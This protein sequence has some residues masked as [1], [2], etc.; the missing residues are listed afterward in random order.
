ME[1]SCAA[2][3]LPPLK[4]HRATDVRA[5]DDGVAGLTILSGAPGRVKSQEQVL[6]KTLP[7]ERK[8]PVSQQE[9]FR[10]RRKS[11]TL[12]PANGRSALTMLYLFLQKLQSARGGG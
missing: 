2:R 4:V 11:R 10:K 7:A 1:S 8:V 5:G 12:P 3:K 9:Q 6:G